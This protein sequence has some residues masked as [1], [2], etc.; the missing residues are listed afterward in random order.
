MTYVFRIE[1]KRNP[2]ILIY[3]GTFVFV[4]WK[5]LDHNDL[6]GTYIPIY[7]PNTNTNTNIFDFSGSK[8]YAVTWVSFWGRK[9][10]V[11]TILSCKSSL[12]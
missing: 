7:L 4:G 3:L 9:S 5:W 11:D 12:H 1:I 2:Y 10:A 8:F 6:E